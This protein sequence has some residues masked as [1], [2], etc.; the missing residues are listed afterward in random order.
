MWKLNHTSF[1]SGFTTLDWPRNREEAL[2]SF[3]HWKNEGLY[4]LLTL[5][6]T[7]GKKVRDLYRGKDETKEMNDEEET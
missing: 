5:Y 1:E 6:S 2:E 3:E 7:S 4:G